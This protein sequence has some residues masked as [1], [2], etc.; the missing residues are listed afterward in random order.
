MSR[1]GENIYFRKDGRWEG[2]CPVG[3]RT[4]GTTRFVSVYGKKYSE[5]KTKLMLLKLKQTNT[6]DKTTIYSDG[7][8]SAWMTYWLDVLC[9]PYVK[10]SSSDAYRTI[11]E[12]HIEPTFG[13]VRL[14]KLN[15][16]ALQIWLD[17]L[18]VRYAPSTVHNIFRVLNSILSKA[19]DQGLIQR[20][21]L[22]DIRKP[23]YEVKKAR[24]LS[25]AEQKQ[26]EKTIRQDGKLE[27]L[28]CLYTGLRLGELCGLRWD[29][30][31]FLNNE[32]HIRHTIKRVKQ[33]GQK[34]TAVI[35]STPKSTSSERT[36]PVPPF[37]M[38]QLK[39][40]RKENG[41]VF[42]STGGRYIDPRTVQERFS[43]IAK[44]AGIIGA[45]MHTLRHTYATRCL[46]AGI[47]YDVLAELLG[48]SSPLVTL[49]CYAHCTGEQKHCYVNK[50]HQLV[51]KF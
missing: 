41:F 5:V 32:L 10:R 4:N 47:P 24:Y 38:Q 31:D 30:V 25:R 18:T 17:E 23:K 12:S 40:C 50:L 42:E 11:I 37:L 43:G 19:V 16:K 48:H 21:P 9:A 28:L 29:D 35:V 8:L 15:T 27:Y 34:H 14:T 45:H 36:I 33:S 1:R 7:T 26:L 20:N 3:K 22:K 39:R 46:E 13:S 49:K 51:E 2:R 6:L 44:Q